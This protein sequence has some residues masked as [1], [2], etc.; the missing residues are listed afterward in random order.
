MY[1][2]ASVNGK[3][4]VVLGCSHPCCQVHA[5]ISTKWPVSWVYVVPRCCTGRFWVV[6]MHWSCVLQ[7]LMGWTNEIQNSSSSSPEVAPRDA[8]TVWGQVEQDKSEGTGGHFF[9]QRARVFTQVF[10]RSQTVQS[11]FNEELSRSASPLQYI[12]GAGGRPPP[13]PP[14]PACLV[15]PT[16]LP[17]TACI[18]S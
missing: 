12:F 14:V 8:G 4:T 3:Q 5:D 7:L 1:F 10:S 13:F 9:K 6:L 11:N 17:A 2:G 18:I 15:A 16:F